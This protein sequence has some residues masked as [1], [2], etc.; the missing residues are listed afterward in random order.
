M[1]TP[2]PSMTPGPTDLPQRGIKATF[3][4]RLDAFVTWVCA[5]IAQ[6]VA[7]GAN[8]Y[9]NAVDAYNSAVTATVQANAAVTAVN[10]VAWV[11]GTTYTVGTVC[12]SP[13]DFGTYRRTTAGA[14]TT[15][16]SADPANWRTTSLVPIKPAM[17]ANRYYG[18]PFL[19]GLANAA[20]T[21]NRLHGMPIYISS[22]CTI[23]KIGVE[24]NTASA[25]NARLGIYN[26]GSDG[27]P[28]GLLL[29]AGTVST[30]TTGEKE[31]AISQA[32]FPG[33]Y[34]L[35]IVTDNAIAQLR[36][37]NGY[38]SGS[39]LSGAPAANTLTTGYA[40]YVAHTYGTLPSL[41]GSPTYYAL[42]GG[43][44]PS[45]WVRI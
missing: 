4:A 17:A 26:M 22:P 21:A 23:T 18:Y 16:P 44:F 38:S 7:M 43:G 45:L 36:C 30:G 3:S 9:N 31:V 13:I 34:F 1:P 33:W 15:D 8:V 2:P 40:P 41:F 5:A 27:L 42:S 6:F 39:F 35:A 19:E 28:S 29:D 20:L 14:G 11:S 10:A 37:I 25:G 12:Y 24:V 32:L